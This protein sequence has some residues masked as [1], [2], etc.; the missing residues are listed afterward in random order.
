[1]AKFKLS[2]LEKLGAK[3]L[4]DLSGDATIGN[5]AKEYS[6]SGGVLGGGGVRPISQI[7][8]QLGDAIFQY[9]AATPWDTGFTSAGTFSQVSGKP[10]QGADT[11]VNALLQSGQYRDIPPQILQDYNAGKLGELEA[12]NAIRGTKQFNPNIGSQINAGIDYT[13]HPGESISDYN[14]RVAKA[15]GDTPAQLAQTQSAIN[16]QAVDTS[17]KDFQLKPNESIT[18][19]GKRVEPLGGYAP[20]PQQMADAQKAIQERLT[21]IATEVKPEPTRAITPIEPLASATPL[22]TPL[23]TGEFASGLNIP[24]L[25]MPQLGASPAVPNLNVTSLQNQAGVTGAQT[26]L[27]NATTDLRNFEATLLSEQ[28]KLK[29]QTVS[30]AVIGRQTAKLTADM[31]ENYRMKQNVVSEAQ[32]RLQMANSTLSTIM[33]VQKWNYTQAKDVYDS[34]FSKALQSIQ[35]QNT[36]R[37]TES[38]IINT[39]QDN[40]RANQAAFLKSVENKAFDANTITPGIQNAMHDIDLQGGYRIGTTE[41]L[42]QAQSQGVQWDAG[43]S[44]SGGIIYKTGMKNGVPF[45]K[46]IGK[47]AGGTPTEI[48]AENYDQAKQKA[49]I[50]FQAEAERNADKKISPDLYGSIRNKI[51]PTLK[52]DFD[53]WAR[54]AGYLSGETMRRFGI[55]PKSSAEIQNPFD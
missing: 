50:L 15:R 39:Q 24:K 8:Y 46:T 5:F 1:M 36:L 9:E 40:A 54:D 20:T 32:G 29:G 45:V 31:A 25:E 55:L 43:T 37:A 10:I 19:Y 33:D 42:W 4:F 49:I 26:D 52:D 47:T 51:P 17:N 2:D 3:P 6:P 34:N 27:Q 12:V 11:T 44:E 30:M 48:T 7:R 28:D 13:L 18:D 21:G 22:P 41:A 14:I 38:T 53:R 23:S 16:Q 35:L